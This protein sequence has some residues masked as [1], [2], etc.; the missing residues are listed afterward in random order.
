MLSYCISATGLFWHLLYLAIL[1][2]FQIE[3]D[4]PQMLLLLAAKVLHQL[5]DANLPQIDR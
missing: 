1:D 2:S 4:S 5:I 3:F